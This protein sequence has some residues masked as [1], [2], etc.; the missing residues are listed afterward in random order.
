[1]NLPY[2]IGTEGE[3]VVEAG[4]FAA[5]KG[6]VWL[7]DCLS[8][9]DDRHFIKKDG[10]LD[11][12]PLPRIMMKQISKT[13]QIKEADSNM[14]FHLPNDEY[15]KNMY[16]FPKTFFCAKNHGTGEIEQT[17]ETYCIHNFAMSWIPKRQRS[18]TQFKIKLMKIFGVENINKLISVFK[19]QEIKEF[20]L[21]K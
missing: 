6:T 9:Y 12:L 14:I 3:G 21:N 10:G 16:M 18:L 8:Y 2:F 19:L 13:M 4:V 20:L 11:T 5:E 15:L 1:M 7:S 17:I